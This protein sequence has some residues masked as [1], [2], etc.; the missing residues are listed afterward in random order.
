MMILSY[1]VRGSGRKEKRRELRDLI[2]ER[3]ID[4]ACIQ[5][6]KMEVM[7]EKVYKTM[8]G[9]R[10][11]EWSYKGAEG[12]SGGILTMWNPEVFQKISEWHCRGMLVVSG[13]WLEDDSRCTI[14]NVYAPN[15]STQRGELWEVI[16][17]LAEQ[18]SNEMMCV[19]GDFNAIRDDTDRV[20]RSTHFD[21]RDMV[22]FNNMIEGS[23]LTKIPLVSRCYT[24]YRSDGTCKSKLDR[25]LGN[26]N[27]L[28]KW[29]NV[30]LK[31]GKRSFSDHIPIFFEGYIKN[32]GPKPFKFFNHWTLHP[33]YKATVEKVWSSSTKQGWS[34]FTLKERL[35]EVKI[36]LKRWSKDTFGHLE[37]RIEE[38]K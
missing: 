36:E 20:G 29:P 27:W 32:W 13:R 9:H 34:G 33:D 4:V 1:N 3:R 37:S 25:L 22:K 5:E 16:E 35:K 26:P 24:W 18:N 28:I 17:A 10:Q 31:G 8:W 15:N 21:D 7:E 2:Q 38:K 11:F 6:T 23:D 30:I 14:V 19:I 12:N